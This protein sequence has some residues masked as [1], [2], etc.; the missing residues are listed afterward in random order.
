VHE[1]YALSP[2]QAVLRRGGNLL[3]I[4]SAVS[5]ENMILVQATGTRIIVKTAEALA[6]VHNVGF[7]HHLKSNNIVR[8]NKGDSYEPVIID[9]VKSVP[10]S[11]VKG[12]K[13][14][15]EEWKRCVS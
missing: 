5:K 9:F 14:F 4:S 13:L 3:S 10:I 11:G 15:L 2:D 12:P 1:G 7:L 6:R 8:D